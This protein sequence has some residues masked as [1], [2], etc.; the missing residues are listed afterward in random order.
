[1]KQRQSAQPPKIILKTKKGEPLDRRTKCDECRSVKKHVTQFP[2]SNRNY[3][4]NICSD[5][6]PTVLARSFPQ[7]RSIYSRDDDYIWNENFDNDDLEVPRDDAMNRSTGG[8]AFESNPR[9][10]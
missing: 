10:H 1:M 5:C 2:K 6:L 7:T 4:V 8:G 9:R 3:R